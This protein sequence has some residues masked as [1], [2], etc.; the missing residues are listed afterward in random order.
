MSNTFKVL[1]IKEHVYD[2]VSKI[3]N[4]LCIIYDPKEENFFY[5]GT[6]NNLGQIKYANYDGYY[7]ADK[8]ES[9][10]NFLAFIFG[11][12]KE[13]FTTELHALNILDNEYTGLNYNKLSIKMSN[14][15]LLSAY[16][17]KRESRTTFLEYLD[18]L[19]PY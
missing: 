19:V 7:S 10:V 18:F 2:D 16:D 1:H 14:R 6:R 12:N 4:R 9:L 13:V 17:E 8:R 3:D 5:Y 11:D 15:T